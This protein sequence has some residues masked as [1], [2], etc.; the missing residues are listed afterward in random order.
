MPRMGQILDR[1]GRIQALQWL[2]EVLLWALGEAGWK[3]SLAAVVAALIGVRA[4][5]YE[6]LSGSQV[7]LLML[8]VLALTLNVIAAALIVVNKLRHRGQNSVKASRLIVPVSYMA[9]T[10][11]K[12]LPRW[13]PLAI[14]ITS[15]VAIAG[16]IGLGPWLDVP[17]APEPRAELRITKSPLE[18]KSP[19][20]GAG[21][22]PEARGAFIN[23]HYR[24]YGQRGA[25]G[26]YVTGTLE[27]VP[28]PAPS[29]LDEDIRKTTETK[30][31]E[32]L[33]KRANLLFD[34]NRLG[35]TPPGEERFVSIIGPLLTAQDFAHV[36]ESTPRIARPGHRL[37]FAA[38]VR[39]KDVQQNR[40]IEVC[41]YVESALLRMP[42]S[43]RGGHSN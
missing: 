30:I 42:C 28:V 18:F 17:A 25:V 12:I 19:P 32:Q 29:A 15:I 26:T 21:Y 34:P 10:E 8:G 31:M 16:I 14:T 7:A 23:L 22:P 2:A 39:Y 37:L 43:Y 27:F 11:S 36:G 9:E 38:I 41:E 13:L 33:S 20:E 35:E 24:N 3:V 6:K 5:L 4:H 40:T 1:L